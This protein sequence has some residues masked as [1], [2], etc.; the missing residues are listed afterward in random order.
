MAKPQVQVLTAKTLYSGRKARITV[1]ITANKAT[2]TDGIY[3]RLFGEQGWTVGGGKQT[4]SAKTKWPEVLEFELSG[5]TTLAAGVMTPFIIDVTLPPGMAPSHDIDPAFAR[6]EVRI[7]V[8]I[9][10]RLDGRYRY[11]LPVSVPPP[12]RVERTPYAVRSNQSSSAADKPRIELSLASTRL[13]AGETL[14]GTCAVYHMDDSK[15]REV[16]LSLVPLF[17]LNSSMRDRERR[18][19]PLTTKLMLPAGSAGSGVPFRLSLPRTMTPSFSS[20]THALEWWLVAR[21][22]SFFGGRVDLS[23][24]LEIVDAS[25]A[26]TTAKLTEAPRLGDERIATLFASFAA[27][28]GWKG[29]DPDADADDSPSHP[30][31]AGS[32]SSS[33]QFSIEREVGDALIRIAYD[34]R[35]EEGT[36]MIARVEHR[37]LGLA[38]NVSPSSTMRHV[39]WKDIEVDISTWDRAHH[40]VARFADQA[41]PFL[42]EVVPVLMKARWLGTMLRWSDTEMVWQVPV[43]TVGLNDLATMD[44]DLT[45]IAASIEGAQGKIAPPSNITV[46]LGAWRGLATRCKGHLALGDMSISGTYDGVAVAITPQWHEGTMTTV[47]VAYGDPALAGQELCAVDLSLAKPAHEVLGRDVAEALVES[48]TR[49]PSDIVNLRVNDGVAGATLVVAGSPPDLDAGRVRELVEMLRNVLAALSPGS[50]PYR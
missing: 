31:G 36:F 47:R 39:F 14:V 3:A 29:G 18:G 16:E 24:P 13:V 9:P 48:L 19:Y 35:G 30:K 50:G 41:V 42:K 44:A 10:W 33:G 34:Y 37:P 25:A 12:D 11:L 6:T 4:I 27:K 20:I 21:T 8:S 15:E 17:K 45:N 38:L 46:D 7:H 26:A 28:Y 40:V 49:W 5:P 22:G 23:V 1:E 2:K 43:T 32:S